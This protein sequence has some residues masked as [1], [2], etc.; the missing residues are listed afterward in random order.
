MW[1]D[2]T[3]EVQHSRKRKEKLGMGEALDLSKSSSKFP[4]NLA[5]QDPE[6]VFDKYGLVIDLLLD[7]TKTQLN[8]NT[9]SPNPNP[10]TKSNSETHK[11]MRETS[12]L[13]ADLSPAPL[14]SSHPE[15][16]LGEGK[17]KIPK[18]VAVDSSMTDT[19]TGYEISAVTGKD[20]G[21]W[22]SWRP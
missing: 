11:T 7:P 21:Y 14:P 3:K 15:C 5:A 19:E 4:Q 8:I 9:G 13:A 12:E 6:R 16:G 10:V 17:A 20:H 22:G 18:G 2:P 1:P